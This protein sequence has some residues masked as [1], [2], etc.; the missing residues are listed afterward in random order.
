M[1]YVKNDI[2]TELNNMEVLSDLLNVKVFEDNADL[3]QD[4]NIKVN[5]LF[6][7][8]KKLDFTV[9]GGQDISEFYIEV[10]N[11]SF[12][13]QIQELETVEELVC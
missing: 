13:I 4:D 3:V 2:L 12:T 11:R 9:S 10:N 7:Y 8:F 6:N 5:A 1:I